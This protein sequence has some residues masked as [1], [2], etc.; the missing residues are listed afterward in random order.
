[1]IVNAASPASDICVVATLKSDPLVSAQRGDCGE[2]TNSGS[3]DVSTPV[4]DPNSI[5]WSQEAKAIKEFNSMSASDN[6][7][8]IL[9]VHHSGSDF[10]VFL[11]KNGGASWARVSA[12]PKATNYGP[13]FAFVSRNG[14]DLVVEY[15]DGVNSYWVSRNGG[16][17]WSKTNYVNQ[18]VS[19]SGGKYTLK[20]TISTP[21]KL[22]LTG[23]GT[24]KTKDIGW[25]RQ[26][27]RLA[28]SEDGQSALGMN[29]GN[30][31]TYTHDG[32]NSWRTLPT[33]GD[34]LAFSKDG[35]RIAYA[36]KDEI[37]ISSDYGRTWKIDPMKDV[38]FLSMSEDGQKVVVN[39]PTTI[40][41]GAFDNP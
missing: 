29:L 8:I 20:S 1:M 27:T 13:Q 37:H 24:T 35:R 25:L 41:T 39:T 30:F 18:S 15:G 4:I 21:S 14:M 16:S 22:T 5:T 19:S 28:L 17:S 3:E 32:G 38:I 33:A 12:I 2:N 23:N 11:S 26:T 36:L 40:Y 34:G 6:G 7:Q 10:G 31:M 9:G